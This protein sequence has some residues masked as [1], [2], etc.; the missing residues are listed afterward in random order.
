MLLIS[1]KDLKDNLNYVMVAG[2]CTE[3][4][5]LQIEDFPAGGGVRGHPGCSPMTGSEQHFR[6]S[7]MLRH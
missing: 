6:R 1:S 3:D 2:L 5:A 7:W 4:Q